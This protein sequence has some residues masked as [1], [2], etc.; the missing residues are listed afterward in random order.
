MKI[1][2]LSL[3]VFLTLASCSS[4][5]ETISIYIPYLDD[6]LL[7]GQEYILYE[8]EERELEDV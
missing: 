8:D 2:A 7:E 4:S 5:Q 1:L 6:N 3:I